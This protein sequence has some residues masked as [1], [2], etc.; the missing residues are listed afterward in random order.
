MEPWFDFDNHA[1]CNAH[2]EMFPKISKVKLKYYCVA[3]TTI[4]PEHV[5]RISAFLLPIIAIACLLTS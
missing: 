4:D 3:A 1:W 2:M 5:F